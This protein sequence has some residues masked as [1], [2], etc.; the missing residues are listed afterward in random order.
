MTLPVPLMG[1][2]VERT[3]VWYD[4]QEQTYS[5]MQGRTCCIVDYL[6]LSVAEAQEADLSLEEHSSA[7]NTD[8]DD[9]HASN[10][11]KLRAA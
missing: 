2:Q 10:A 4:Q 6:Q 8:A 11:D 7:T 9:E 3:R 5:S 1:Y